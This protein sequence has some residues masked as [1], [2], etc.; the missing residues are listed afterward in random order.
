MWCIKSVKLELTCNSNASCQ[1]ALFLIFHQVLHDDCCK[2]IVDP[3]SY[4]R[5]TDGLGSSPVGKML[6]LFSLSLGIHLR[7]PHFVFFIIAISRDERCYLGTNVWTSKN[8]YSQF[9]GE[10]TWFP[11]KYS[12][13]IWNVSLSFSFAFPSSLS[14][15][16]HC[17]SFFSS[18]FR[19]MSSTFVIDFNNHRWKK[20]ADVWRK[21]S[22]CSLLLLFAAHMLF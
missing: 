1:K 11:G 5:S 15:T 21:S 17:V 9:A 14:F 3:H 4:V 6:V 20:A 22:S 13:P 16:M 12:C 2:Q 18:K 19:R 8:V 10:L 7:I